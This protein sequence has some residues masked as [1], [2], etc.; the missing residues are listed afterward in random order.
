[1]NATV[2]GADRLGQIPAVLLAHGIAIQ[3]HISG[4]TAG[5][6]ARKGLLPRGTQLLILFTDF[7]NHNAM[8]HFRQAAHER[9]I[10][11]LACKRSASCLRQ[12][13]ERQCP[14]RSTATVVLGAAPVDI[15]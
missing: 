13:L 5:D 14:Q 11:V 4:R 12:C 10:P 9:G 3:H 7:L 6:H 1:M 2:V 8:R 15:V